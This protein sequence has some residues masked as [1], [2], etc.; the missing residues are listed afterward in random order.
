MVN[1]RQGVGLQDL[2]S[3][4]SPAQSIPPNSG[5]IQLLTL[6]WVPSPHVVL[7]VP[8]LPHSPQTPSTAGK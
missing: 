8:K 4:F 3:V 2:V 5:P 1:V 6:V 7:Q